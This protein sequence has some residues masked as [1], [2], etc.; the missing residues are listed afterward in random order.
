MT[1]IQEGSRKFTIGMTYVILGFT[2]VGVALI[3]EAGAGV[4]ASVAGASISLATGIGVIVWGN[5][6]THKAKN[7][8]KP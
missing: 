6:A 1:I 4:I 7:G 3:K 2:C 8:Q 5:V